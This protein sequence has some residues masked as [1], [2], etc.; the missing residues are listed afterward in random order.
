MTRWVVQAYPYLILSGK[1]RAEDAGNAGRRWYCEGTRCLGDGV[2][3]DLGEVYA[4]ILAMKRAGIGQGYSLLKVHPK[5]AEP[6][7]YGC[8]CRQPDFRCQ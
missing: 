4:L 3:A 1:N 6:I 2:H 8:I 5:P 7:K